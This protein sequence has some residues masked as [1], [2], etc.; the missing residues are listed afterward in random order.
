ML[1]ILCTLIFLIMTGCSSVNDTI[2]VQANI[3]ASA[4]LNP[5]V[6]RRP[7]PILISIYQLKNTLAFSSASFFELQNNALETLG[8]TLL[9]K[10]NIEIRPKQIKQIELN[11]SGRTRY[12]GIVAAYRDTQHAKWRSTVAIPFNARKIKLDVQ[13]HSQQLNVNTV[14]VGNACIGNNCL[15]YSS[16]N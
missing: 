7:S 15:F 14:K 12:L 3:Q 10:E 13:L 6:N 8:G 16:E 11:I 4:S 2:A 1:K 5:D 9:E